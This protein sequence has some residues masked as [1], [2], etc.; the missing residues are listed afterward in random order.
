MHLIAVKPK[1]V[2]SMRPIHECVM[3]RYSGKERAPDAARAKLGARSVRDS[4]KPRP[5][6][7]R[8][9]RCRGAFGF[10]TRA[11]SARG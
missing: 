2:K 5:F 9:A 7:P 1:R 8:R 6:V 11:C 10:F 4:R 3:E